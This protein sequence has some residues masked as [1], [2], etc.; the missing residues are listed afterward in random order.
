MGSELR[1]LTRNNW[2]PDPDGTKTRHLNGSRGDAIR[3]LELAENQLD[4]IRNYTGSI[5]RPVHDSQLVQALHLPC[6]C[7]PE[8]VHTS[9]YACN[10]VSNHPSKKE[11]KHDACMHACMHACM[12]VCM[13]A[14]ICVHA[15]N[16]CML[17]GLFVGL[18]ACKVCV[19]VYCMY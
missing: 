17:V 12:Y 15:C 2:N 5:R 13:Y 14:C 6:A 8:E 3:F 16:V 4:Q 7:T 1:V 10:Y 9:T 19:Y 18:P 11:R